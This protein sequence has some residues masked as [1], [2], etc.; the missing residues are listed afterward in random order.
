MKRKKIN[1]IILF[2]SMTVFSQ[3]N[4]I[5]VFSGGSNYIG[6]IG[7]TT[8]IHPFSYNI[9][10]NIVAGVIFRKNLNERIALRAKLNYAKIGSSDNWPNTVEYREERGRY[11]KN[12]LIELGLAIDFNFLDFDIHSSSLQMTPYISSGI[13]FFNYNALRYEIGELEANQYGKGSNI[14]VPITIGYKIKPL[15]NFI[16]GFEITANQSFSDN[17]D[18]SYP[19]EKY[20]DS[21]EN[22]GST[23]S[24]DW[25]VF[26]GITL[27]YLFGN[28][29]CYC[30]N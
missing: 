23:L 27:T 1:V 3:N 21:S 22:F 16:F 20:K 5:G 13:N 19:V 29:K 26:S 18:G 2:I 25:Y 8:Y 28:K 17:L 14:S 7:P 9:S 11:F 6:D 10:T 24:K 12:T 4:E 30:P 15:K